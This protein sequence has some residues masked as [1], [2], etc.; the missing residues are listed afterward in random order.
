MCEFEYDKKLLP[1]IPFIDPA[2][3]RGIWWVLKAC[4]LKPMYYYGMLKGLM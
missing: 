2:I 1:T 3:E 4:G